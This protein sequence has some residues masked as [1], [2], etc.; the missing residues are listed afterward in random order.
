VTIAWNPLG[1]HLV[2]AF[3]KGRILN[4]EYD[5]DNI[6]TVLIPLFLNAG[7]SQPIIHADNEGLY[8]AH[9]CRT[10]RGDNR[11]RL[12][13]HSPSLPNL[14]PSEF[15]LFQHVKNCLSGIV[16]PSYEELVTGIKQMPRDIPVEKL[17]SGSPSTKWRDENGC[18]RTKVIVSWNRH[19][20]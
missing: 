4:A 7:D 5:S 9:K 17:H 20:R 2:E 13:T 6:L 16:F 12:A 18:L 14:A 8:T 19:I 10:F 11:L 15:F 1:F 3:P